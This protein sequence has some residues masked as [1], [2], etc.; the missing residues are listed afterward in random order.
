[1]SRKEKLQIKR[2]EKGMIRRLR[3]WFLVD[4]KWR[5]ATGGDAYRPGFRRVNHNKAKKLDNHRRAQNDERR[6]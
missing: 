1:M 6:D 5:K 4:V 3:R 2:L